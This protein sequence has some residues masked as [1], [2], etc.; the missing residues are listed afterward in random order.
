MLAV[1]V[2]LAALWPEALSWTQWARPRLIMPAALFLI[3][4]TMPARHL[5]AA[6]RRPAAAL[7]AVAAGYTLPPLLGWL[8]GQVLSDDLRIGL[9]IICCVPCTLASAALWTRH[10]GGDEATALL[11]TF[12]SSAAGWAATTGLLGLTTGRMVALDY[13]ALMLDLAATL[14]VP[15][16]LGQAVRAIS[17]LAWLATRQRA[18]LGVLSRLLVLAVLFRAACEVSLKYRAE[19]GPAGVGAVILAGAVCLTTHTLALAL[20]LAG[21]RWLGFARPACIAIAFCGSQKTLP[22]SLV[23]LDQFFPGRP[24]AVLP[25]VLYHAGQL[26]VD[27]WLAEHWTGR[28][29][30][31]SPEP[32]V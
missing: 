12:L 32:G 5:V 28:S 4:W 31:P 14:L 6:M 9:M 30:S 22:V 26:A 17:P 15:V 2:G 7:W 25:M 20:A 19:P 24:L 1:G 13:P 18:A 16:A 23:V 29:P 3:A 21:A 10:A 8:F 27:T 11:A